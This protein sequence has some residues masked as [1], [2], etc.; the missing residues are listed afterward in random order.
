MNYLKKNYLFFLFLI[1]GILLSI[2]CVNAEDNELF[3]DSTEPIIIAEDTKLYYKNGTQLVATLKDS[4]NVAIEN[5][6]LV[7]SINGQSYDRF[8]NKNGDVFLSLNLNPGVYEAKISSEFYNIEKSVNVT[9]LSTLKADDFTKYYKNDTY[10]SVKVLANNGN[11]LVNADVSLNVNGLIYNRITNSDGIATLSINLNPGNYILTATNLLNGDKIS[12]SIVVL[13]TIFG[14]D[15]FM[16]F[17][18]GS[19]YLVSV[20]DPVGNPLV[21]KE[22]KMNING[23]EYT[24]ITDSNG[25]ATLSINLN[26]GNYI[27]TATHPITGLKTSNTIKIL[28]ILVGEDLIMVYRDG[29]YNVTVV[30]G[31]GNPLANAK[32]TFNVN[33]IFYERISDENGVASLAINLYPKNYI[34]TAYYNDYAISNILKVFSSFNS[35]L[36]ANNIY[37][38]VGE[39][40]ILNIHL[41]DFLSNPISGGLVSIKIEKYDIYYYIVEEDYRYDFVF[42]T[43]YNRTTD[44]NGNAYLNINLGQGYYII[45]L[46]YDGDMDNYIADTITTTI[47]VVGLSGNMGRGNSIYNGEYLSQYLSPTSYAQSNN[48]IIKNLALQITADCLTA[49]EKANAIFNYVNNEIEYE[50]YSGTKYG[51][52]T[53]LQ[54]KKGNCVDQSHL[55]VALARAADLPTR[56]GNGYNHVWTQILIKDQNI[57]LI[58]DP[59]TE[60]CGIFG[61]WNIYTTVYSYYAD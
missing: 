52:L 40:R 18:N 45:T 3:D 58:A 55:I 15:L 33:G 43:V 23:I 5:Q 14:E 54:L 37:M 59:T 41:T 50:L 42:E 19:K 30:D 34:I 44:D 11:P 29:S 17:K 20:L 35:L 10:Y 22:V 13:E 38:V 26:P 24:R 49:T 16:Y 4:D 56:Y 48:Q 25:I 53:T 8:T 60:R 12:S 7:I 2:S 9:I 27:I 36:T 6:L 51:A 31:Y 47:S 21:N 57:W 46:S 39:S 1:I 28:P 32:V 61:M